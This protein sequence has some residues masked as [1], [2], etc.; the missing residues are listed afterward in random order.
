MPRGFT[1]NQTQAIDQKL[2]SFA[3]S[4][5]QDSGVRKTTIERLTRA[6]NISTGAFY[7]FYP[8]KEALFFKVYEILEERI[9]AQFFEQMVAISLDIT[10]ITRVMLALL[11]SE[12]MHNLLTLIGKEDLDY[13]LMNIDPSIVQKHQQDDILFMNKV[14]EYLHGQGLT[15]SMDADLILSYLQALFTLC[16]EKDRLHPYSDRIIESFLNAMFLDLLHNSSNETT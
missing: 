15:T 12:N 8:S 5:I 9:K 2:I 6:A 1:D 13:I 14:I 7:N 3:M 11:D 16:Y 10:E 4:M